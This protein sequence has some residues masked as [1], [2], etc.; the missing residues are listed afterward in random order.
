MTLRD[1]FVRVME[2]YERITGLKET[3]PNA[4][5]ITGSRYMV[6]HVG[7]AVSR[8]LRTPRAKLCGSCM[9]TRKVSLC[10]SED[11]TRSNPFDG[12][13]VLSS[14]VRTWPQRAGIDHDAQRGR[15]PFPV[16]GRTASELLHKMA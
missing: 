4:S 3:N 8:F 5:I 11:C 15:S 9:N 13:V 10:L 1:A 16:S 7:G 2:E 12:V 14:L 6:I